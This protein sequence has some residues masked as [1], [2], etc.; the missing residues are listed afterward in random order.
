MKHLAL[1][2][3]LILAIA[4]PLAAQNTLEI[5]A[6][7]YGAGDR[8]SDVSER[9]RALVK[10]DGS[11]Q[12]R[13]SPATL[14]AAV[15]APGPTRVLRIY[16]KWNGIFEH[17]E[18]PDGDT[19]RIG[20]PT[21]PQGFETTT[22]LRISKAIYGAGRR[23]I[24]VTQLLQGKVSGGKVEL[25]ITNATMGGT[26][27][28]PAVV[29]ALTVSYELDGRTL[30]AL[31]PEN[32]WLRIPGEPAATAASGLQIIQAVYGTDARNADVTAVLRTL[33]SGDKLRL[34]V[35]VNTLAV[36]PARGDDKTLFV[37]YTWEGRRF[38]ARVDDGRVLDLPGRSGPAVPPPTLFGA[39]T[40]G[41]CLHPEPQFR[42]NPYCIAPGQ[43]AT[44]L[45]A[46]SK[47]GS[48]QFRGR[49]RWVELFELPGFK[50]RQVRLESSEADL[51]RFGAGQN[52][53]VIRPGSLKLN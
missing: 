7:Y 42:G 50:G 35:G 22:G 39:T 13:V 40:D 46:F 28:A 25:Q 6:A 32:S 5:I 34:T 27:P 37:I 43:N 33:V 26:D 15:A 2:A 41:V 45:P 47:Y 44:Q 21:S 11:L 51:V 38:E 36:D 20:L 8:F 3:T 30:E 52:P 1:Q 12:L 24:D 18:W 48:L 53:W 14:G 9:T 29:K 4:T 23:T 17:K 19:A 16:Y 10:P 31:V 49:I